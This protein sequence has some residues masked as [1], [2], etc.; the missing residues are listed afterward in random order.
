MAPRS[1]HY[2]RVSKQIRQVWAFLGWP[3]RTWE[4]SAYE[5]RFK[6][7]QWLAHEDHWT[8]R[9]IAESQDRYSGNALR[10][11]R[12]YLQHSQ[13]LAARR[14][15]RLADRMRHFDAYAGADA[16]DPQYQRV[17]PSGGGLRRWVAKRLHEVD[18]SD[19]ASA[20]VALPPTASLDLV[21]PTASL[22]LLCDLPA[23]V[24]IDTISAADGT[25]LCPQ[26]PPPA[27]MLA[28]A[29]Q[30]DGPQHAGLDSCPQG[31]QARLQIMGEQL[32]IVAVVQQNMMELAAHWQHFLPQ[33][34]GSPAGW[35]SPST[36]QFSDCTTTH[37]QDVAT[38]GSSLP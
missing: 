15:K 16:D 26:Q 34:S 33:Q 9:D 8:H 37:T 22:D 17:M 4:P 14:R 19:D 7:A 38:K 21:S 2:N 31:L 35:P 25:P 28:S 5:K 6:E 36:P 1:R 10:R 32:H 30:G 18:N 3:V 27:D 12:P 20:P 13:Y 23:D 11:A 24:R 29:T